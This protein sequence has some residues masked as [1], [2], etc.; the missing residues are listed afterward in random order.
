MIRRKRS[1]KHSSARSRRSIK[2]Q[3][4]PSA[5]ASSA[6]WKKRTQTV[7]QIGAYR[8]RQGCPDRTN[9]RHRRF[10]VGRYDYPDSPDNRDLYLPG[11]TVRS[12]GGTRPVYGQVT[13]GTFYL[14]FGTCLSQAYRS[15]LE[16]MS[17]FMASGKL[18]KL[19]DSMDDARSDRHRRSDRVLCF[20]LCSD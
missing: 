7:K 18:D 15:G 19:T 3:V 17:A 6:V 20:R 14:S 8:I 2:A 12:V 10:P 5:T 16:G 11:Y 13:F 9:F 1:P 4:D